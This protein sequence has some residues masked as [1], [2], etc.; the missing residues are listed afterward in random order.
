SVTYMA[1]EIP[2][3][4]V[5]GYVPSTSMTALD[6]VIMLILSLDVFIQWYRL[7]QGG[8]V[9]NS[10]SSRAGSAGVGWFGIDLRAAIPFKFLFSATIL[11]LVHLVKLA[12]VARRMRQWRQHAVQHANVLRL[13]FFVYWLL[14]TAHWLACGWLALGGNTTLAD[15]V[16][17]EGFRQYLR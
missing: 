17:V 15:Q 11:P 7:E 6:R 12:R 14:L 1:V 9:M 8:Q 5:V 13:T 16:V 4:L 10:R 3:R 2:L